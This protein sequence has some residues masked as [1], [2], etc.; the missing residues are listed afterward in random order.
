MSDSP[1]LRDL[2]AQLQLSKS[3]VQRVLTGIG[4]VS[5]RVR[6]RV[7]NAA[8][9]QGYRPNPLYSLLGSQKR[10]HSLKLTKIAY[11]F[12]KDFTSGNNFFAAAAAHGVTLGYS[13]EQVELDAVAAGKRLMEVLYNR[14]FVGA[15]IGR[16][17]PSDHAAILTNPQFPVVC[18]GRIDPLPLHTVHSDVTDMVRL[19][20]SHLLKAG[21]RRIGPAI[22]SHSPVIEDDLDRFATILQC[23]ADTL[24]AADR[25]P[26]FRGRFR[27]SAALVRWARKFKPDAILGFSGT[28]FHLLKEAGIDMTRIGFATLHAN[29]TAPELAGI[30][31][32]FVS[33]AHQAINLLDQLIRHRAIGLPEEPLHILV[34]GR[35]QP[36]SSLSPKA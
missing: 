26:S 32:P 21:Y 7:L 35:W 29:H 14:G 2:A 36:G 28:Q 19:A 25:L 1:T 34:G 24:E 5:P 6:Q 23:Q 30:V 33:I 11:L 31:E 18:C 10:R 15:L 13:I 3:T 17:P 16:V 22:C 12:R 8:A 20:W 9:Q 27:D 4:S